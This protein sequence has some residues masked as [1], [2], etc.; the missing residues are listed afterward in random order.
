MSRTG[1]VELAFADGLGSGADGKYPFRLSI[2]QLREL[3]E[4]CGDVGPAVVAYRLQSGQ[5]KVDDVIQPIRLGLI[6]AGMSAAKADSLVKRYVESDSDEMLVGHATLAHAIVLA[7]YVGVESEAVGEEKAAR[8]TTIP[9]SG[10]PSPQSMA[11][12]QQPSNG[13]PASSTT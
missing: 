1:L 3:Q 4:L 13:P 9:D 6:G 2:K 11:P 12:P 10:S 5:W 7:S 8:E